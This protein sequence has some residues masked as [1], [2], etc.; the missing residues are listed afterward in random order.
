MTSRN[1]KTA[2]PCFYAAHGDCDSVSRR[3]TAFRTACASGASAQSVNDDGDAMSRGR[4]NSNGGQTAHATDAHSMRGIYYTAALANRVTEWARGDLDLFNYPAWRPTMLQ[5]P[6]RQPGTS[7]SPLS[8]V[9]PL[10][11]LPPD[12]TPQATHDLRVSNSEYTP[13]WSPEYARVG[14]VGFCLGAFVALSL[15]RATVALVALFRGR[16]ERSAHAFEV[17]PANDPAAARTKGP[18]ERRWTV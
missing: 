13:S 18:D 1:W 17:V 3:F 15:Q 10:S 9:R 14:V 6:Q 4:T 8:S 7:S 5:T 12:A 2:R 11:P 16:P